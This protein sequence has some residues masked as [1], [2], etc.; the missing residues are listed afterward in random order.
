MIRFWP[1]PQ[2]TPELVAVVWP[3]I[4]ALAAFTMDD[5]H[6]G[7][8]YFLA[9]I[10][11]PGRQYFLALEND[12]IVG[13]C[14][15]EQLEQP[16]KARIHCTFFDRRLIGRGTQFSKFVRALMRNSRLSVVETVTPV[17]HRATLVMLERMGWQR[18][19]FLRAT[20][21]RN[22][23]FEDSVVFSWTGEMDMRHGRSFR[24]RGQA[25]NRQQNRTRPPDPSATQFPDTLFF[26]ASS[27]ERGLSADVRPVPGLWT[28]AGTY[29]YTD[30]TGATIPGALP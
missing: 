25:E 4:E 3:R 16:W 1:I 2:W 9:A 7:I 20:H 21:R 18:D 19:G 23:Q 30:L 26:D 27:A 28:A 6:Q 24:R 12:G 8:E 14:C 11:Q 29:F 13:Y 17:S 22:G 10:Q 15:L 5:D